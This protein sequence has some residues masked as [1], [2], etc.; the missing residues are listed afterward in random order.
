MPRLGVTYIGSI[1]SPFGRTS[2]GCRL[3]E[4][5]K[6]NSTF[7]SLHFAPPSLDLVTITLALACPCPAPWVVWKMLNEPS[8]ASK[9]TG[10]WY[11]SPT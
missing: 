11:D 2:S 9:I 7:G 10:F 4:P 8:G 1:Q 3:N 6:S 5:G